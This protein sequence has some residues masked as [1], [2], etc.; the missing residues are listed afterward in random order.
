MF[1]VHQHDK[2][3]VT[4]LIQP[5]PRKISN[6]LM[7]MRDKQPTRQLANLFLLNSI[8]LIEKYLP[9][10]FS[11]IRLNWTEDDLRNSAL[12]N[13]QKCL[14]ILIMHLEQL[15]ISNAPT[16]LVHEG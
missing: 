12:N 16:I 13:S 9:N 7:K 1:N 11:G 10:G 2:K 8:E 15:T 6:K 3:F 5:L 4:D 14:H